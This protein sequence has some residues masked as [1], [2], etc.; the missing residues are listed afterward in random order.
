[1]TID[2]ASAALT[3]A[4]H[5]T[6]AFS[7]LVVAKEETSGGQRAAYRIEGAI[8]KDGTAG[9]TTVAGV[10]TTVLHESTGSMNAT[11]QAG[12]AAG[13]LDLVVTGVAGKTIRWAAAVRLGEVIGS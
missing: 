4:D 5:S 10:T 13:T 12:T 2:G 8:F 1:M 11:A 3:V 7:I 6:V 9:S